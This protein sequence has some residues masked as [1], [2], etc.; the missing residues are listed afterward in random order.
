MRSNRLQD[1]AERWNPRADT[2]CEEFSPQLQLTRRIV[3]CGLL[4]ILPIFRHLPIAFFDKRSRKPIQHSLNPLF[5]E[6]LAGRASI[7]M[8]YLRT[9][10][11]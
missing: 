4:F 6:C 2:L 5:R 9:T 7:G 1:H 11:T 8:P 3:R 10:G